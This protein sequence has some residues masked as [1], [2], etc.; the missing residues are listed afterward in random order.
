MD[1]VGKFDPAPSG[2][3]KPRVG[4]PPFN[5]KTGQGFS[6]GGDLNDL[7][8]DQM[9]TLLHDTDR[10]EVIERAQLDQLLKEQDMEGIVKSGEMA[11]RGQVRGVDY[12]LLGKVSNLRVKREDKS[13]GF[14][15]AQVGGF[16]NAGGG[17]YKKTETV[18]TTEAG[19]DIRL[20]DPTSGAV[21]W[22]STTDFKKTDAASAMGV[23]I[24]GAS[25]QADA[26]IEIDEDS[27]GKILRLALDDAIKK[28]LKEMDKFLKSR[29][30]KSTDA[31]SSAPKTTATPAA[32]APA[33]P[34]N[35]NSAAPAAGAKQKFC[36]ECG[37][38]VSAEAKFCPKDG[39]AL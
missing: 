38:P 10:F 2:I 3:V 33:A 21:K 8:A 35:S 17:D 4:V 19:V 36:P 5:V 16:F 24:L 26:K 1:N 25:A 23:D 14:G 22:A 13:T 32:A 27:K 20:V 15:L 39:K 11:K 6:G 34:A 30:V 9:T 28:K 18:I 29:E 7:A 37:T 12:L 31:G